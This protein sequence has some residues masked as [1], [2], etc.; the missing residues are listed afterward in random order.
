LGI[1]DEAIREHLALKRQSGADDSELKKIEDEAFGPPLRPGDVEQP[2]AEAVAAA[3]A[4]TTHMAEAEVPPTTAA[5]APQSQPEAPPRTEAAP[6]PHPEAPAEP[7]AEQPSVVDQPTEHFDVQGEIAA[8]EVPTGAETTD[9]EQPLEAE[10]SQEDDFF[11]EQS[12]SEELDQALDSTEE[13][14]G[15][16]EEEG[17]ELP[18]EEESDD[19]EQ[20]PSDSGVEDLAQ[21]EEP[22]AEEGGP[23]GGEFFDQ[24]DVLEETP[25][26]LQ[27]T[28]E[29]DRLWFE[30]KPPKDF[31]FDD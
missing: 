22:A 20:Q 21:E 18:L 17:D 15:D 30:Q 26:F 13:R 7:Q 31:D 25:E 1:L 10:I 3:E 27:D 28:P 9:Q 5:E 16:V 2:S 11:D 23:E 14:E 12:L 29:S 24:E 8:N 19:V 6:A 4:P